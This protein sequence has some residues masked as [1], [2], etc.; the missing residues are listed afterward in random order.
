MNGK[1]PPVVEQ[2]TEDLAHQDDTNVVVAK[3]EEAPEMPGLPA[4]VPPVVLSTQCVCPHK[5][6]TFWSKWGDLI[7]LLIAIPAAF[8]AA[9]TGTLGLAEDQDPYAR[10]NGLL[11]GLLIVSWLVGLC[12][13]INVRGWA[14]GLAFAGFLMWCAAVTFGA[15]GNTKAI[16]DVFCF[17][18]K[19]K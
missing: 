10:I 2:A 12:Q 1:I 5:K 3:N 15:D 9:Y 17:T 8:G 19:C 4:Q 7:L 11:L 14:T 18:A 6:V 16:R 13:N